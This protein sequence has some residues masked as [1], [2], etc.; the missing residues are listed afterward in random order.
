MGSPIPWHGRGTAVLGVLLERLAG[1][2]EV[3]V[4]RSDVEAAQFGTS[5]PV[6]FSLADDGEALVMKVQRP[7]AFDHPPKTT[8]D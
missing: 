7:A 4:R 5:H 3:V 8:K 1:G 6:V 2:Q